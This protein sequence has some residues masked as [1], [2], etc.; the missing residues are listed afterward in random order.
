MS[1]K[2]SACEVRWDSDDPCFECGRD[3]DDKWPALT[4]A[5]LPP[6]LRNPPAI[7]RFTGS[8]A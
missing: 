7:P 1:H 2:C 4:W 5:D 8:I 3:P 6:E